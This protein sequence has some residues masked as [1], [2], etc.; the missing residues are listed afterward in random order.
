MTRYAQSA[1]AFLII[2]WGFPAPAAAQTRII[3]QAVN[4]RGEPIASANV[5]LLRAADS[6]FVQH[7]LADDQRRFEVSSVEPGDYL[8]FELIGYRDY[9][10]EPLQ[11]GTQAALDLGAVRLAQDT[12]EMEGVSVEARRTFYEQRGNRLVV[13][14]WTS[15]GLAGRSALDILKRSPGVV[16]NEQSGTS[17]CSVR[18]E[19][20]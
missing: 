17:R 3:G 11:V 5:Q 9:L 16:V 12:I 10:S 2:L 13:N 4:E 1:L 14:V 15:I 6:T 7:T 18:T 8:L 19:C 20:G